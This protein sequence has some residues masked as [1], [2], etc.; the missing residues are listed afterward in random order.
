MDPLLEVIAIVVG[1]FVG[2][3]AGNLAF[4]R[5]VALIRARRTAAERGRRDEIRR[6][7]IALR[8]EKLAAGQRGM[9]VVDNVTG[10]IE[11]VPASAS[12]VGPE[13]RA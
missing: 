1:A 3:I 2:S 12:M 7:A 11:W 4:V 9:V 5:A 13:G 6:R 8:D 10:T